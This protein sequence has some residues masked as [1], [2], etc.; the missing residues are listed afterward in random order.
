MRETECHTRW[1]GTA[2]NG[3]PSSTWFV[4]AVVRPWLLRAN[5]AKPCGSTSV[6]RSGQ[7]PR[8]RPNDWMTRIRQD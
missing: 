1:T 5:D 7:S 2:G 3:Q 8:T 6:S 4:I